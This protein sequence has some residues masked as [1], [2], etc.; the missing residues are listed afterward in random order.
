MLF[1]SLYVNDQ[2][3]EVTGL[4]FD[5]ALG[6]GW[7]KALHP[8]DQPAVAEAWY[9]AARD[10]SPFRAEY[11]FLQADGQ[12]TWVFG[13][14]ITEKNSQGEVIGYIGSVTDISKRKALELA[15]KR[16][17]ERERTLNRIFQSIRN[18]L[19]LDAIFATA[20]TE[21]ARLQIGRAHV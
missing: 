3:C 19:N 5:Q 14:A 10:G 11:R 20:T 13:R 4:P 15:L 12:V 8:S 1:R 7:I 6:E 9:R 2:W 17:V 21:T 16:Q 18:S